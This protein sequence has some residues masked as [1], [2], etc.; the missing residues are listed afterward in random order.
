MSG[1]VKAVAPSASLEQPRRGRALA[2][3]SAALEADET[4]RAEIITVG[5]VIGIAA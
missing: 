5:A 4:D 1:W 3:E 2:T